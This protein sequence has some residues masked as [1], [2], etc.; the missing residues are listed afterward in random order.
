MCLMKDRVEEA[1]HA[2]KS[3]PSVQFFRTPPPLYELAL[4]SSFVLFF[5]SNLSRLSL[6]LSQTIYSVRTSSPFSPKVLSLLFFFFSQIIPL[7]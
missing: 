1:S 2:E 6:S 5:S 3:K 4:A 7:D